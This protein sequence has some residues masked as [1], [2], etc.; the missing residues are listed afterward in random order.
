MLLYHCVT[1][2]PHCHFR[3]CNTPHT[4]RLR[5]HTDRC[6]RVC[7]QCYRG[8]QCCIGPWNGRPSTLGSWY[9]TSNLGADTI[10]LAIISHKLLAFVLCTPF[11]WNSSLLKLG[12][13]ICWLFLVPSPVLV[14]L[15]VVLVLLPPLPP[16]LLPKELFYWMKLDVTSVREEIVELSLAMVGVDGTFWW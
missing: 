7:G 15:A 5:H 2:C 3:R 16:L 6:C 4:S 11:F 10:P 9:P 13:S 14:L 12:L 8:I 1:H